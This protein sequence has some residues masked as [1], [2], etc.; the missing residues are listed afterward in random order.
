MHQARY[1]WRVLIVSLLVACSPKAP[2]PTT[3]IAREPVVRARVLPAGERLVV[4][5]D[6]QLDTAS[7]KAGDPVSARVI[8]PLAALNPDARAR[9]LVVESRRGDS[10]REPELYLRFNML[11]GGQLGTCLRPLRARVTSAEV[12]ESNDVP[13]HA[14]RNAAMV[15]GVMAGIFA[16]IPGYIGGFEVGLGVGTVHEI[17]NRSSD[18]VLKSGALL[19]LKLDAPLDLRGCRLHATR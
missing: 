19:T 10:E 5:L 9:G 14:D 7:A 6:S 1:V 18:T 16:G 4:Q 15:G 8:S 11:D 2:E 12:E 13:G 17:R 3:P